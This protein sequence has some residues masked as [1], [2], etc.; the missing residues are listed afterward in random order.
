MKTLL[1]IGAHPDDIEIGCG[2]T[3]IHFKKM[4]YQL[5]HLI[6]TNGEEGGLLKKEKLIDFANISFLLSGL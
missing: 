2:G 5:I 1:S 6:V 4:G 3:E